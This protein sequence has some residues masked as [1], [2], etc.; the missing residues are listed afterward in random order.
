[1]SLAQSSHVNTLEISWNRV[2]VL[3]TCQACQV[4]AGFTISHAQLAHVLYFKG[5]AW[6]RILFSHCLLTRAGHEPARNR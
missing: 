4:M 5:Y 3:Q 1:M 6:S 2:H